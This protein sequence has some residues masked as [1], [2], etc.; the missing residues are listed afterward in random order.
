MKTVKGTLT[1]TEYHFLEVEVPDDAT[2][3]QCEEALR[4]AF[5]ANSSRDPDDYDSELTVDSVE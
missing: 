1:C 2:E 3:D 4:E 5:E